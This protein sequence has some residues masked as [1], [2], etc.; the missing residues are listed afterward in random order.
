MQ[1]N[2][3]LMHQN[4]PHEFNKID[5]NIDHL[6]AVLREDDELLDA[7][8]CEGHL[9]GNLK[10]SKYTGVDVV[11]KN[12]L[13]ARDR[14]HG[15]DFR[16]G[17][18]F[19]LDGK[20]DVVFCCRVLMHL[21]DYEENVKKLRSLAR[22]LLVVVVPVRND[23]MIIETSGVEFRTYSPETIQATGPIEVKI[24]IKYSTVMYGPRIS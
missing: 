15:V 22:R 12:I 10:H 5:P 23:S 4:K 11:E 7:G 20:W 16:V 9:Y 18:I 8:C 3:E 17:D 2:Y 1:L 19:D 24:G 6:K 14:Y 13:A 21:P